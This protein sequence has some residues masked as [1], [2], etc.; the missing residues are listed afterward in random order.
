[1]EFEFDFD[2]LD[3]AIEE[4]GDMVTVRWPKENKKFIRQEA[5]KEL[6]LAKATAKKR[7]KTYRPVSDKKG[8]LGRLKRGKIFHQ[9]G[10]IED[11]S[12][13]VYSSAP[14][15]HLIEE[16]HVMKTHDGQSPKSGEKF[17]KG[18]HILE[19]THR[20]FDAQFQEDV[21]KH[22]DD[23]IAKGRW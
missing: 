11:L 2:E 8:Y 10:D 9:D 23:M 18:Y 6:K 15:G 7:L 1:M 12:I 4:L 14:H 13:R 21:D 19:D 16:G 5:S 17:V 22:I 3:K 20:S